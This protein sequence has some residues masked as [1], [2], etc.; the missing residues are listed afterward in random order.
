MIPEEIQKAIDKNLSQI[1]DLKQEIY[2]KNGFSDFSVLGAFRVQKSLIQ[3]KTS[4]KR[5]VSRELNAGNDELTV[6]GIPKRV[7][8][9]SN[10]PSRTFSIPSKTI[11]INKIEDIDQFFKTEGGE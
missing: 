1:E 11:R 7:V 4:L 6:M 2:D 9:D 10:D 8:I 5:F 3:D